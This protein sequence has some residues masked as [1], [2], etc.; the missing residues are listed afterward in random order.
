MN[1]QLLFCFSS[2]STLKK[3]LKFNFFLFSQGAWC[4]GT[5]KEGVWHSLYR[6]AGSGSW[7]IRPSCH[8]TDVGEYW[9]QITRNTKQQIPY[10]PLKNKTPHKLILSMGYTTGTNY[11]LRLRIPQQYLH[12]Q[13]TW[14]SF[15]LFQM[16]F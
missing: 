5:S 11:W 4:P 12:L 9:A 1:F 7:S 14:T 6:H 3:P 13:V 8:G 16:M 15:L 10:S 2:W